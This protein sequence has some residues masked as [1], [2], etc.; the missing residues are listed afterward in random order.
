MSVFRTL[1]GGQ[2]DGVNV[3]VINA[4]MFSGIVRTN[5]VAN[6]SWDLATEQPIPTGK[7]AVEVQAHHIAAHN[8]TADYVWAIVNGA[9]VLRVSLRDDTAALTDGVFDVIV[10]RIAN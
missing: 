1:A 6:G 9:Q 2:F 7:V 4:T 8:L 5:A 10:K 3:A